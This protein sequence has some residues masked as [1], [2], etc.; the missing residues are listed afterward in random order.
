[1]ATIIDTPEGIRKA[2]IL[3]LIHTLALE[4][5]SGMRFSNRVNLMVAAAQSGYTGPSRGTRPNK[6]AAL[7]WAVQE[8]GPDYE[9]TARVAR[10]LEG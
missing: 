6:V 4:L 3:S 2:R 1:M 10:A 5:N 8:M 9:P 7:R